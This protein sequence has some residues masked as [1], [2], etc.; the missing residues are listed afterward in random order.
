MV[1]LMRYFVGSWTQTSPIVPFLHWSGQTVKKEDLLIG[2]GSQEFM[3]PQADQNA[4]EAFGDPSTS[5]IG[6][7]NKGCLKL[8]HQ[9]QPVPNCC[10]VCLGGYS[11]G[12][13]VVWSSNPKCSHAFHKECIIEWL[14]KMQPETPCPCCRQEFT[15]LEAVRKEKKILWSGT[16]FNPGA[17]TF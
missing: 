6:G 9:E 14:V 12:D 7:E 16:A 11:V 17:V 5:S 15:D 4:S 1:S 10:A 3:L 13:E 8:P 2:V